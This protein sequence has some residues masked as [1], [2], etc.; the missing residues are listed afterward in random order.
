MEHQDLD[1]AKYCLEANGLDLNQPNPDEFTVLD[2]AV[3]TNNMPMSRLLLS[4]GARENPRCKFDEGLVVV[5]VG[6]VVGMV[7]M[8]M[9]IVILT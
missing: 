3:M 7:V 1:V 2:I 5:V 6:V 8:V 9:W 4:H